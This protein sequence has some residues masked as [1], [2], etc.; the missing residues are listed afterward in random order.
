MPTR[1]FRRQRE[2]PGKPKQGNGVPGVTRT[3]DPRFH[4][5]STFAAARGVR[6]LDYPFAMAPRSCRRRPSSLYTFPFPGL[7]RDWHGA[8]T[9]AFPDFERIRR[10]VSKPDAQFSRK[11]VLYPAELRRLASPIAEQRGRWLGP[12]P[13]RSSRQ[14]VLPDRPSA[15]ATKPQGPVI[16]PPAARLAPR[17]SSAG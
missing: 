8:D 7:A 13:N 5:T 2:R 4:P 15:L 11:P 14:A 16:R 3:R 9:E 1:T 17:R 6:G 12:A 10:A